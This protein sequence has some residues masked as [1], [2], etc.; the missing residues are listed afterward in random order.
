MK[1]AEASR[2]GVSM[3]RVS[4]KTL[5]AITTRAT[6]PRLFQTK[7]TDLKQLHV[8]Q[9][10]VAW[11]LN[12]IKLHL[13]NKMTVHAAFESTDKSAPRCDNSTQANDY[14]GFSPEEEAKI[15]QEG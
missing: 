4:P 9:N 11:P 6:F 7:K 15:D 12:A 8:R 13:Q 3:A 2:A 1:I 14:I 5:A 10:E